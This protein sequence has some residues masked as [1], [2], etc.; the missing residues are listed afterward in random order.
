MKIGRTIALILLGSLSIWA[1]SWHYRIASPLMG[2]LGDISIDKKLSGDRY[3]ID[4]EVKTKGI[5]AVLTGKRREHYRSEGVVRHGKL[6]SRTLRMERRTKKKR[7]I[8]TY[9]IDSAKRK[10]VKKRLR[11]KKGKLDSN[12]S[13]T[14][15]YFSQEDLL[16]L[17]FNIAP[18][19]LKE[20]EKSHWEILAVGA[21]KIKGRV[22][23][24]RLR[25]KEAQKARRDLKVEADR[26]I[27]VF[28]SPQKIAGKRNRRFTV[29]IDPEGI[30]EKIRFV[31]IPV[32]GVIIVE[33]R[34]R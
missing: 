34:G 17:Y 8:D 12:R 1:E 32:V 5:A 7:Q 24:D 2:T 22:I 25:G 19:L 11:W 14:L 27:V 13:K 28:H 18:K 33:R 10:V 23:M 16:T 9:I 3:R 30:P 4:V 20:K 21:E 15:P 31:A 26:I 29:A 6:K